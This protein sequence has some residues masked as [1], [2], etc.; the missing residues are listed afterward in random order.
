MCTELSSA[1]EL[2]LGVQIVY[3]EHDTGVPRD[4]CFNRLDMSYVGTVRGVDVRYGSGCTAVDNNGDATLGG[5]DIVAAIL[6][7][8]AACG[9]LSVEQK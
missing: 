8:A 6:S 2:E 9:V 4:V 5:L 7:P 1:T 3:A